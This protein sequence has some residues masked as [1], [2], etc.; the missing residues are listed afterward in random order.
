MASVATTI[1]L[2][3]PHSDGIKYQRA[4][5]ERELSFSTSRATKGLNSLGTSDKIEPFR[6][7]PPDD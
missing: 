1:R 5:G 3:S 4:E 6:S 2:L 7:D